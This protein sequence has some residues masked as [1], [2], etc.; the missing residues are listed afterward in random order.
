MPEVRFARGAIKST[1]L[2]GQENCDFA[3]VGGD[4]NLQAKF[5]YSRTPMA[6]EPQTLNFSDSQNFNLSNSETHRISNSESLII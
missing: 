6:S 4:D 2:A 3:D 1:A 5:S